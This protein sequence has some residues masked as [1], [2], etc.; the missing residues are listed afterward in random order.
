ARGNPTEIALVGN[1]LAQG[2]LAR[3]DLRST[4]ADDVAGAVVD[5]EARS[6]RDGSEA[7]RRLQVHDADHGVDRNGDR[8]AD[9]ESGRVERCQLVIWADDVHDPVCSRDL[10]PANYP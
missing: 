9:F 3:V 6:I 5:V 2:R 1:D 10:A 8:V 7:G 4:R